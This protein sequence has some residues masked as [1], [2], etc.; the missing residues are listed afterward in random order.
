MEGCT[1]PPQ[2]AWESDPEMET[3]CLRPVLRTL[4]PDTSSDGPL[5]AEASGR[6]SPCPSFPSSRLAGGSGPLIRA[7]GDDEDVIS[8]DSLKN[9][10]RPITDMPINHPPRTRNTYLG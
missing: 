5:G 6:E 7:I 8:E 10:Q 3:E 9:I 4:L 1:F 2:A